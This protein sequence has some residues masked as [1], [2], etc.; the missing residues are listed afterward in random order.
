MATATAAANRR[1][2][3][4]FRSRL[5]ADDE[6]AYDEREEIQQ[7]CKR[8]LTARQAHI[9]RIGDSLELRSE[10]DAENQSRH[11]AESEHDQRP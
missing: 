4:R 3:D 7:R 9:R 5:P 10:S 2:E 1:L 8:H 11:D 6:P